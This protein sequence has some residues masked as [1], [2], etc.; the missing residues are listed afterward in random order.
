MRLLRHGDQCTGR[1][2]DTS[3]VLLSCSFHR[4]A[5][6]W[7]PSPFGRVS[8]YSR[9]FFLYCVSGWKTLKVSLTLPEL[10]VTCFPVFPPLSLRS[11]GLAVRSGKEELPTLVGLF[12]S[13]ASAKSIREW[14]IY[15]CLF[16]S[17]LS[18]GSYTHFSVLVMQMFRDRDKEREKDEESIR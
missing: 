4:T 2:L 3:S 8:T 10:S 13:T 9:F 1:G 18:G 11:L 14:I 7:Q 16:L 5:P 6:F 15:V 12:L 17:R